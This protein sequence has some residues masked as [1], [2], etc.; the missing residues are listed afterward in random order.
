MY[1]KWSAV[2]ACSLAGVCLGIYV[3][4][5][6]RSVDPQ[7]KY[8]VSWIVVASFTSLLAVYLSRRLSRSKNA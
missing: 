8:V 3:Y 5:P 4:E 6:Q 7:A 1:L 2:L